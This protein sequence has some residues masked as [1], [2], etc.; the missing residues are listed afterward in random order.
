MGKRKEKARRN[1]DANWAS[2]RPGMNGKLET[3]ERRKLVEGGG[4]RAGELKL[5]LLGLGAR[6]H[7]AG[8]GAAWLDQMEGGGDWLVLKTRGIWEGMDLDREEIPMWERSGGG[9]GQAS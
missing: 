6:G 4:F 9:E 3:R 8:S 1:G 2:H 7:E 5:L